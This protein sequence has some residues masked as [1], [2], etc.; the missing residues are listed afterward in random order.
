[1]KSI[2]DH[3][4]FCPIILSPIPPQSRPTLYLSLGVAYMVCLYGYLYTVFDSEAARAPLIG[5]SSS[6]ITTFLMA[7]PGIELVCIASL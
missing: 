2:I 1:M 7:L 4:P 3:L 5:A 6:A